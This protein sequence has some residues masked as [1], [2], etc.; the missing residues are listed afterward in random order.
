VDDLR[1]TVISPGMGTEVVVWDRPC[2]N[3]DNFNIN[4][5]DEAANSN[6]PCPPL[7][8]LTY[9]PSNPMTPF[10]GLISNGTW[11]L[12][13]QDL[14]NQDGGSLTSWGLKVC[15]VPVCQLVVNQSSGSASGSLIAAINCADSGDTITLSEFLSGQTIDIG[16]MPVLLDKNLVIQ[17]NGANISISGSGDRV[18][19]IASGKQIQMLGFRIVAGVSSDGGIMTNEGLVVIRN[20]TLDRNPGITGATLVGNAPGAELRITGVCSINQ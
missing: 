7:D 15:G 12:K 9:K 2:G 20:M 6:W 10:D 8:G 18:F 4:L 19:E 5:D 16:N 17:A 1:F 13:I 14:V 11:T 3:H